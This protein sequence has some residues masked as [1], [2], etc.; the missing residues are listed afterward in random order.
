MTDPDLASH[1]ALK[2]LAD[3]GHT[4]L[5]LTMPA[6]VEECTHCILAGDF[7]LVIGPRAWYMTPTH[8]DK[9][10]DLALKAAL[11]RRYP[12]EDKDG[13]GDQSEAPTSDPTLPA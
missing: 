4:I 6:G 2:K 3:Q 12:K 9:Y 1:P 10:L 5:D 7:D 11:L 13:P 8:L